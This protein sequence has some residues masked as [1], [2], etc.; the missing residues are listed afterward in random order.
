[1]K[2]VDGDGE[3]TD[4]DA[5]AHGSRNDDDNKSTTNTSNRPPPPSSDFTSLPIHP[6]GTLS[7]IYR[8]CVGTP[9]QGMLAPHSRGVLTFDETKVS[10]E[11]G[12]NSTN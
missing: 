2:I 6:V 3:G 11:C 12:R 4:V 5:Q 1:M 10:M 7:S 9:R 8:L